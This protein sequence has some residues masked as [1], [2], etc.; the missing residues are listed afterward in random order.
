MRKTAG[1]RQQDKNQSYKKQTLSI[2][3][4]VVQYRRGSHGWGVGPARGRGTGGVR[5]LGRAL[6]PNVRNAELS[7]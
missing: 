6:T 4:E 5:T 2:A 7:A 3:V 1:T